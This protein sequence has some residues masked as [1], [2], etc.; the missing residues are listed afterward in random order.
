MRCFGVALSPFVPLRAAIF[1][2]GDV[3]T[4]RHRQIL[5]HRAA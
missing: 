3:M 1:L 5:P 4:S 2:C